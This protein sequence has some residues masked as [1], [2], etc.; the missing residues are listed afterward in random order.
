MD[1]AGLS[2]SSKSTRS[3]QRSGWQR[4]QVT[5]GS[6]QGAENREKEEAGC[7]HH[8]GCLYQTL[9]TLKNTYTPKSHAASLLLFRMGAA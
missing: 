1:S 6:E 8:G 7:I 3:A 2:G 9:L 5:H 4:A